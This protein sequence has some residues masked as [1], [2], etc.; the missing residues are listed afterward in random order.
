MPETKN[1]QIQGSICGENMT[2]EDTKFNLEVRD[3]NH[4]AIGSRFYKV[5]F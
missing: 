5:P 4:K 3:D 1:F 2:L